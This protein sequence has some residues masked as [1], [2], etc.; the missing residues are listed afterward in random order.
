MA[1][2][3]TIAQQ[4][5]GAGKTT[6]SAHLAVAFCG[7]GRRV[8][9]VDT[10]PQGTLRTWHRLRC[11]QYGSDRVGVQ[12]YTTSGWQLGSVL[13]PLRDAYDLILIDSPPHIE[14]EARAAIRQA[15]MLLIP[16]Q[17]SPADLWA[18]EATLALAGASKVPVRVVLNRV[19]ARSNLTQRIATGLHGVSKTTLGNRV[20]FASSLLHGKTALETHPNSPAACETLALAEEILALFGQQ[21]AAAAV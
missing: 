18:T 21:P 6:L 13:Q 12:L 2:T 20:A 9:I 19:P 16:I 5:G 4:K 7:M 3:I 17:P 10:D 1:L 15:D 11:E 14:T 8:A